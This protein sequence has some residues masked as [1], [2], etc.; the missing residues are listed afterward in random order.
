MWCVYLGFRETY[1]YYWG[2]SLIHLWDPF[3]YGSFEVHP[4]VKFHP[5]PQGVPLRIRRCGSPLVP[6]A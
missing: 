6:G 1:G 2:E 4:T 5:I 3:E